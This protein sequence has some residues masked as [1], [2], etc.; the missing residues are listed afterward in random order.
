MD[1][2]QAV[3]PVL[4]II[5]ERQGFLDIDNGVYAETAQALVQPPVDVLI[6]FLPDF[7]VFPVQ[8]RLF[9]MKYMEILLIGARQVLP[10]RT[11][12]IR[13]PVRRQLS[14]FFVPQI[15]IVSICSV[16]VLTGFFEPFMLIRAVV[17]DQ[18][19]EDT[20]APLFCLRD[21][22]LH[23]LHGAETG[24]DPVVVRDIISLV[25]QRRLITR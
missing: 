20:D 19:H 24:I 13:T 9:L 17:D 7:R 14:L 5:T 3:F 8:V 10:H 16:R 18:V 6:N 25:S 15:K 22:I 2:A 23:I 12:E 4:L 21:Q 11:A 1:A